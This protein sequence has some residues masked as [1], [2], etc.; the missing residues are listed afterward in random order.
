MLTWRCTSGLCRFSIHSKD[1]A[2]L[3]AAVESLPEPVKGA[4]GVFYCGYNSED[5][6]GGSAWLVTRDAGNVMVDS[7]R[8]D[9]KLAKRIKVRVSV[10]S[11]LPML[12]AQL[13]AHH[14][15]QVYATCMPSKSVSIHRLRMQIVLTSAV[16]S[17]LARV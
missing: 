17:R 9:P 7:P 4:S 12:Q 8:F 6:F 14:K 13:Q 15:L 10:H 11:Q 2:Q 16:S 3:K 5:S 1:K